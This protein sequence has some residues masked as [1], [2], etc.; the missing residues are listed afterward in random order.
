M[1]D[2]EPETHTRTE[3]V[4]TELFSATL[5][6]T[7]TAEYRGAPF[8]SWNTSLHPAQLVRQIGQLKEMGMGGFFMHSRT[9]LATP[10]LG[11]DFMAAVEACVAKAETEGMFAYLYD[12]DRWPSGFAGG[13]VTA[14]PRYRAKH[15]LITP[16]PYG[17]GVMPPP[18]VSNAKGRRFEN[19]TLLARYAVTL[20]GGKL[21]RYRRLSEDQPDGD[22]TYYAYLER[23]EPSPWWNNQ[24]YVDTLSA[25]ATERFIALTHERYNERVGTHFGRTVPAIFTDEPQVVHVEALS[26]DEAVLPWT[27]DFA[28]TYRAAYGDD[29]LARLPEVLW[30]RAGGEASNARY[31]YYDHLAERFAGAYADTLGRW[32][33]ANGLEL[34]GHL[35]E[36]PTLGSQTAA[37]GEAMRHYRAFGLPGID[38]LCDGMELNTAKQA[39][40]AARQYGRAGVLSELYGVTNWDFDFAGHKRQGDWQAACGVTLRAHHLTWVSMAGEAKRDYPASIGPQSPWW[41]EYGLVED[42]FAR[43]NTALTRG[44]PVVRVGVVHPVE[45]YWLHAG[46]FATNRSAREVLER[47]FYDLTN[48]LLFG[49]VDFDFLAESSLPELCAAGDAPLAVGRMRYQAVVVP[50][51][52]TLRAS[53]LERLE[54]FQAAGGTLIFLGK[55]PTLQD[56]LP[57]ERAGR[58]A[59]GSRRLPFER[60]VFLGALGPLRDLDLRRADG[61]RTDTVL[62]TLRADGASRYLYLCNTSRDE[63]FEGLQLT[64]PGRWQLTKLETLDGT[65]IPLAATADEMRTNLEF[66][67]PAHGSLLLRLEPAAASVGQPYRSPR[68]RELGELAGPV[69]VTL[70]EPNALL[71]NRAEHRLD[72]EPWQPADEILRL[73]NALRTRL[74]WPLRI[75]AYAQP[76]TDAAQPG[77]SPSRPLA[78][79]FTVVSDIPV[80]APVLAL[81]APAGTRIIWNG[82]PVGS[83]FD[84]LGNGF[85]VDEAIRTVALPP[86]GPGRH[87][88]VLELSYGPRVDLEWCYLLGDFGVEVEGLK[89]RLV[90]PVRELAFGDVTTQG[91]PFYTGNVVYHATVKGMGK[92]LTLE[93]P[94]FRAPLLS[95]VLDGQRAGRVAFAPYRLPLGAL[96]P[97]VHRLELTVFGNRFN[98]FGALHNTN[99][100][101]RWFGP[102]AWRTTGQHWS[103]LYQL[104]PFGILT[105]PRLLQESEPVEFS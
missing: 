16:R 76:W 58:L 49:L 31:R 35:M 96:A 38:M 69:P 62:Y 32:C 12:E 55:P 48:W 86:F 99:P 53:T 2:T 77:P 74:G 40:S 37:L 87:E 1:A 65:L 98:A 4:R 82:A 72:G 29:L 17:Y 91:L 88:L 6:R 7:P 101:E 3:R 51:L 56:A 90:A 70:S 97:G 54:A 81:E 95:A 103:D 43:L 42:H 93:V 20:E 45:S 100:R 78:L 83:A 64:V 61:R 14:E 27:T 71:L 18:L 21:T 66:D 85:F 79:R 63:G 8:W 24:T 102:S 28:D 89:T 15:L 92:A 44:V 59:A 23:A 57:S 41:R 36:E 46:P 50:P 13:F 105:P 39:Q 9:G 22:D 47:Q 25:E 33:R 34:T 80:H 104:K 30:D 75:D 5:F 19:G 68:Y 73:D 26:D 11:D 10:Y 52:H 60:D 67:L 84:G 94:D